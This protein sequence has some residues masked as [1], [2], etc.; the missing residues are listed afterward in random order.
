[1]HA[2]FQK[3]VWEQGAGD[4][5]FARNKAELG[6]RDLILPILDRIKGFK[7]KSVLE[8]GSSNGWRLQL[9][10]DQYDCKVTGIDPSPA[11][12]KAAAENGIHVDLGTADNLPYPDKSFDLIIFGFCMCL[13]SPEDWLRVVLESD[14][15]LR[16]G[17][18]I[19]LY[20]LVGSKFYKRRM[21]GITDD[22]KLEEKPIYLY[23]YDWPK[24]WL[25]YPFYTE[26]LYLF[27]N[28]KHEICTALYKDINSLLLD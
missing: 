14:R 21:M 26:A 18:L 4:D 19:L 28:R 8:V 25:A 6:N 23:T 24:L 3:S 13:I 22:K 20:D 16:D 15:V 12:V 27:D 7:T 9:I 5:W 17:G 10:K 11:A 2:G 1:M